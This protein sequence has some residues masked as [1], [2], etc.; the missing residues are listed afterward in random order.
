MLFEE[1]VKK[2]KNLKLDSSFLQMAN[3]GLE[4]VKNVME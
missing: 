1:H 4:R 2:K 3:G